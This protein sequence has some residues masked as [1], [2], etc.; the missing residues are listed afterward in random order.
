MVI[1]FVNIHDVS[2]V[3]D[4]TVTFL[5]KNVAW[6]LRVGIWAD[7]DNAGV[8]T[9]CQRTLKQS[10]GTFSC[11]VCFGHLREIVI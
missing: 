6:L 4:V 7:C 9:G 3:D 1:I 10:I 11:P 8:V 5:T 2:F